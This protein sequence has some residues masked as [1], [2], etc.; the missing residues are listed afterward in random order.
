MNVNHMHTLSYLIHDNNIVG[1]SVPSCCSTS[2]QGF[3]IRDSA[4]IRISYWVKLCANVPHKL[5]LVGCSVPPA[6]RS[7]AGPQQGSCP[8][9]PVY[10]RP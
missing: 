6:I 9:L 2:L 7:A 3:G 1:P 5:D 10:G 8:G 4:G